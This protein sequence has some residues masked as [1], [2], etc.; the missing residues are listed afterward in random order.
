MNL[1]TKIAEKQEMIQALEDLPC[2]KGKHRK[3]KTLKKQ[4]KNLVKRKI[5]K[6]NG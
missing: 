5:Y 2:F 3:L 1:L 4:L 6:Y